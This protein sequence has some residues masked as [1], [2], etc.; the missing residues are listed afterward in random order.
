MR[1]RHERMIR[2]R[3]ERKAQ[4]LER[5]QHVEAVLR[6]SLTEEESRRWQRLSETVGQVV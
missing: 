1:Y 6:S 5:Q 2:A 3:D 4:R